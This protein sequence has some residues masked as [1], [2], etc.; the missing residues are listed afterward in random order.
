MSQSS[1]E[2]QFGNAAANYR[3]SAVHASGADLSALVAAAQLSAEMRVLDAGSGAG[4]ATIAV[5]PH[6]REAIAYDLTATMLEQVKLL[7]EERSQANVK[8]QQGDV[9]QLPFPDASFDR[10][11][12]RYSAHHWDDPQTALNDIARVLR[13]AGRFVLSDVVASETP[14]SDSTLQTLEM[15]RDPSHVRD[16]SINQWQTMLTGAGFK[17]SVALRFDVPLHFGNWVARINT[18]PNLIQALR[19]LFTGLPDT[20]RNELGLPDDL[21]PDNDF[22]FKLLGAVIVGERGA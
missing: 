18:P 3:T 14:R 22:T 13:P 10:V 12:S 15:L 8:T 4:H 5:A 1:I 16:H 7:A 6:V 17:P 2:Q 9:H 11:V 20:Q 21:P 19:D